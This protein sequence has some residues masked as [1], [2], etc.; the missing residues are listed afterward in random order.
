[1]SEINKEY[2][3]GLFALAVEEG[4]EMELLAESRE[5]SK[6]LSA[7]YLHLLINPAI[8]KETRISL[9]GE[10]LDGRV[11]PYLANFVKLMTERGLVSEIHSCFTEYESLYYDRFGIIK[12]RAESAV[13]LTDAQKEKLRQKLEAHTGKTVEIEYVIDK[14]LI[15]GM[16]V[17]LN[18]RLFDDSVKMKLKEIGAILSDTVV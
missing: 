12:A 7:E 13:E 10:V 2:G 6:L 14:A 18:G 11:H 15:G 1:M 9:V 16:R 17:L 4:V 5:L 3:G 8:P